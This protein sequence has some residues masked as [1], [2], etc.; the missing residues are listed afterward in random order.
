ME[1]PITGIR[2]TAD[3]GW[4]E[5]SYLEWACAERPFVSTVLLLHGGGVDSASLSW[6]EVGSALAGCG[7]RVIA[8]DHP[9][10]G[11]S[12]PAP[13]VSTQRRLVAYISEFVDVLGLDRYVVG[14]VS[15][16]GGLTL[17]HVLDRLAH[18]GGAML[19]SSYGIMRRLYGGSLAASRQAA[20]AALVRTGALVPL[21]RRMVANRLVLAWRMGD[22]IRDPARRTPAFVAEVRASAREGRGLDAF[23]QWQRDE[24][25]WR[26]LTTDYT[27]RLASFPVPA[28]IVHGERDT[29]V[30]LASAL[31]A[32][33][34][35]PDARLV[36]AAGAG[37]WVQRDRPDIVLPAMR[38]FL[39][40]LGMR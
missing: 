27:D 37:H 29:A 26:R 19:L 28:L 36:I 16:G 34:L 17:G 5:V 24:V 39:G 20:A 22:L 12:L 33:R 18:V 6:G 21:T 3:L 40:E 13:W 30:P 4:G 1:P 14:G 2:S 38:E 10:Y 23:A 15:L 11:R 9:G 32:A 25:G 8:P 35:I 31:D 7:H